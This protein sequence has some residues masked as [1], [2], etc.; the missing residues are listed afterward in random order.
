MKST[1]DNIFKHFARLLPRSK[2]VINPEIFKDK[3][4]VTKAL[5]PK[6]NGDNPKIPPAKAGGRQLMPRITPNKIDFLM[7]NA[8]TFSSD[9]VL[10]SIVNRQYNPNKI[11]MPAPI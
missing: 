3:K 6:N 7:P 10:A 2:E 8:H 11:I 1:Q 9:I 5:I 4:D